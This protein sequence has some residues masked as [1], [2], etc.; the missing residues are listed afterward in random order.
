M[1][2]GLHNIAYHMCVVGPVL[3]S[4][5]VLMRIINMLR[6]S[7]MNYAAYTHFFEIFSRWFIY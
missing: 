4:F 2:A 6:R 1:C 5:N 3:V 7:C